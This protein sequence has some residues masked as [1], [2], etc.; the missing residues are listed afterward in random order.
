MV[1]PTA[2]PVIPPGQS[3]YNIEII[4]STRKQPSADGLVGFDVG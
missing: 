3:N 2:Q 4:D 1:V